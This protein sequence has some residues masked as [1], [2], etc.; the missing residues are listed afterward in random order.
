MREMEEKVGVL[1]TVRQLRPLQQ[2]LV[3][4][5]AEHKKDGVWGGCLQVCLYDYMTYYTTY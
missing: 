3:N 4:I 2:R 5:E 1:D